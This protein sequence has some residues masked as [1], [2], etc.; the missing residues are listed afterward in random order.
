MTMS[1]VDGHVH[2]KRTIVWWPV[3]AMTAVEMSDMDS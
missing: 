2:W 3:W 1:I